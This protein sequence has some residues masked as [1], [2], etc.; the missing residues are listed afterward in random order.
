ME[1]PLPPA[2]PVMLILPSE[3]VIEEL[4]TAIYTP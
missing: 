1:V 2:L 4:V 3:E